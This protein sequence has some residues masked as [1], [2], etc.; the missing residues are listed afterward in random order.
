M[1]CL[2]VGISP[3]FPHHANFQCDKATP[4]TSGILGPF[5]CCRTWVFTSYKVRL[6]SRFTHQLSKPKKNKMHNLPS[7]CFA[8]VRPPQCSF[9]I[10]HSTVFQGRVVTVS[11][12]LNLPDQ[13][14]SSWSLSRTGG[15]PRTVCRSWL[16]EFHVGAT[17]A[18]VPGVEAP[19]EF[20]CRQGV[21]HVPLPT[22]FSPGSVT[23]EGPTL[24]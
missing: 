19:P 7:K 2:L 24:P 11:T 15:T 18:V 1:G 8:R 4:P 21:P 12:I 20:P 23:F 5:L 22:E 17:S 10:S 9:G 14:F 13:A 16:P 3:I 6:S